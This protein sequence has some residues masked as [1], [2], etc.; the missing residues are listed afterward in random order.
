[1]TDENTFR[2][3]L[4]AG[5]AILLPIGLYH[6][7]KSQATGEKLDRRQEGLFILLTLRPLGFVAAIVILMYL[8]APARVTWAAMTLP[9]S[10]RWIGVGIAAAGSLLFIWTFRTLGKNITDTVVTRRDHTLVTTGPY[11]WVRHPFYCAAALLVLGV[12]NWFVLV[13]G[14]LVLTLLVV[15]TRTEEKHLVARFGD[16]YRDYMSRTARFVPRFTS[17]AASPRS[18]TESAT[19]VRRRAAGRP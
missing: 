1:M 6:R 19:E 14:A 17:R 16:D 9:A 2:M 7:V 3:I 13:V 5:A 8:V 15:R 12:A 18:R 10:L 4:I 11:V